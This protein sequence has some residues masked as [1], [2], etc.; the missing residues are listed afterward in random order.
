VIALGTFGTNPA[1]AYLLH[2]RI[3]PVWIRSPGMLCCFLCFRSIEPLVG[4]M[5]SMGPLPD[6]IAKPVRASTALAD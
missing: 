1:D 4:K 5:E 2:A 3:A 6:S